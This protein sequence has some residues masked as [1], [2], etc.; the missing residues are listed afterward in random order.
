[1]LNLLDMHA[2]IPEN[3]ALHKQAYQLYPYKKSYESQAGAA[4]DGFKNNTS[5]WGN[6]CVISEKGK[7]VAIWWVNLTRISSIHHIT[8]HYMTGRKKWGM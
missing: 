4:V 1:M 3:L 7:K 2:F 5:V 6:H 8:V